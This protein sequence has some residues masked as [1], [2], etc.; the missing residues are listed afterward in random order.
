MALAREERVKAKYR[1]NRQAL[2]L[3]ELGWKVCHRVGVGE[4]RPRISEQAPWERI[5]SHF[6]R[7]V[8]PS[9]L[10]LVPK[11]WSGLGEL[12][13]VIRAFGDAP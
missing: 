11:E 12:S 7:F 5:C 1:C 4:G 9:N 8:S 3:N 2:N 13:S 6:R 10:F